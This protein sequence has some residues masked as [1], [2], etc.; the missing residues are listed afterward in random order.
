VCGIQAGANWCVFPGVDAKEVAGAEAALP[1][2]TRI[3]RQRAR[4]AAEAL[5]A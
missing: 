4:R 1:N 2:D 3:R 5:E